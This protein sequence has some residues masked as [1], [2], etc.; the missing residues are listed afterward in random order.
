MAEEAV[1]QAKLIEREWLT[2][3][4]E[5]IPKNAPLVQLQECRRA[6]YAGA[7]ALLHTVMRLSDPG[8]EPT[9]A[10]M[11]MMEGIEQELQDFAKAVMAGV[12]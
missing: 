1:S 10:D 9:E 8:I 4:N 11:R 3:R 7:Q 5:V 6:F 12:K 2:Y